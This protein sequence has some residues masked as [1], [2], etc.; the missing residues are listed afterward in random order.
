MLAAPALRSCLCD[1]ALGASRV[2]PLFCVAFE[3]ELREMRTGQSDLY[4]ALANY[5]EEAAAAKIQSSLAPEI[6]DIARERPPRFVARC[7]VS[8]LGSEKEAFG[9]DADW[10]QLK[11]AVRNGVQRATGWEL[12]LRT[13]WVEVTVIAF[14]GRDHMAIGIES[15]EPALGPGAASFPWS[16]V[17]RAGMHK[18]L[19]GAMAMLAMEGAEEWKSG[20]VVDPTCGM[21]TL[22]L[23]AARLWPKGRELRLVG[24]DKQELQLERCRANFAACGL[25]DSDI[26]LG[27]GRDPEAFRS[28]AEGSV[29]ALVC[30][31]PCGAQYKASSDTTSYSD[32]LGLAAQLL[33]PSGRCVLLST[34]R[35]LLAKAVAPGPWRLVAAYRVGRGEGNLLESQLLALE[36]TPDGEGRG[37][38]VELA[39]FPRL[40]EE[41][42]HEEPLAGRRERGRSSRPRQSRRRN[43]RRPWPR[44]RERMRKRME[45]EGG[46]GREGG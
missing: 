4:E 42:E 1:G 25:D 33:R 19:A 9:P 21:G 26:L 43:Q 44:E 18:A 23:A 5:V 20:V 46:E 2:V 32:F 24:R 12:E 15:P 41:E 39:L 34:R 27:N 6:L 45:R 7:R 14:F 30:D 22:L 35:T 31:L 17:P 28:L 13:A 10:T 36:R 16:R 37:G 38:E 3:E 8:G 11:T 40:D 29:D